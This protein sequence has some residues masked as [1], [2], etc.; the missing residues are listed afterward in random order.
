MK[1]V[2]KWGQRNKER[3]QNRIVFTRELYPTWISEEH[4]EGF[5]ELAMQGKEQ[6]TEQ[7][8]HN[9]FFIIDELLMVFKV[10]KLEERI[11]GENIYR[12]WKSS[13]DWDR[14]Q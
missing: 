9:I 14:E 5:A 7:F 1:H 13:E 12:K 8:A 4:R 11:Y 3:R 10:M 6:E 2:E